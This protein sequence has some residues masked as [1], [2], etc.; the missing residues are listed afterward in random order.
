MCQNG[1]NGRETQ[2]TQCSPL[3]TTFYHRRLATTNIVA[4][5]ITLY[6]R[7]AIADFWTVDGAAP[8]KVEAGDGHKLSAVNIEFLELRDSFDPLD[9]FTLRY[10]ISM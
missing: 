1:Q 8:S 7:C 5:G 10:P 4:A 6:G 2:K 3:T 9:V